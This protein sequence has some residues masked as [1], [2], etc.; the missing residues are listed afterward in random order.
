MDDPAAVGYGQTWTKKLEVKWLPRPLAMTTAPLLPGGCQ[1]FRKEAFI[2]VGGYDRGFKVWGH[3]DEE[4]SFKMWLFGYSLFVDPDFSVMHLFR[5]RHPYHVSQEHVHY[6]FLRMACSH[7]SRERLASALSLVSK[8]RH[9]EK[10]LSSVMLSDVW[11]Q[12]RD[13][14]SKREHDDVWFMKNFNIPF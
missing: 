3:E 5:P 12:R 8:E 6:N 11:E 2:A 10:T 7:F 13:Y 1:A 4:I 9:F 14:L